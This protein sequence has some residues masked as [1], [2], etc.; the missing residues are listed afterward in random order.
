MK[1]K[2]EIQRILQEE[3]NNTLPNAI[4]KNENGV[5]EV[6][7]KYK[8]VPENDGFIVISSGNEIGTFSSTQTALSWC[9]AHKYFHYE[10]AK[11]LKYIDIELTN[12]NNDISVRM[13]LAKSSDDIDYRRLVSIKLEPKIQRKVTL[14]NRLTRCINSAKYWQQRGF[15]NEA[16]RPCRSATSKTNF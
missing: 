9:I 4:W 12:L 1:N 13:S 16:A 7:G 14:Q 15:I 5:Y 6:F 3:L 10:L 2:K 11:E 8:I